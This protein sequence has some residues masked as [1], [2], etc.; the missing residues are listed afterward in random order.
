MTPTEKYQAMKTAM[1]NLT[2]ILENETSAL[3]RGD[4]QTSLATH[5]DKMGAAITFQDTLSNLRTDLK[6]LAALPES[7]RR[8]LASRHKAL[9]CAVEQNLR[10]LKDM[11]AASE[12]LSRL[13]VGT[14]R[15]AALEKTPLPGRNQP[16]SVRFNQTI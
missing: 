1:N 13:V 11:Q 6:N 16:L 15:Q 4:F 10:A 7:T 8:D 5:A 14:L 3:R 12:R 2:D 9:T